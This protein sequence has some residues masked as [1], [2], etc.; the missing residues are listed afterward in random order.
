MPTL[1]LIGYRGTGK[2]TVARQLAL[3]LEWDW[4]DADVEIE[5]A[6]GKSIAAIFA[7]DG[8]PAFRELESRV[9]AGLLGRERT[10]VAAGGGAVLRPENRAAIQSAGVVVWLQAQPATLWQRLQGDAT[11]A[12]RR[13]DL[14]RHGGLAEIEALLAERTPWYAA[15]ATLA[16]DTEGKSPAQIADEILRRLDS[17]FQAGPA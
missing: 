6:A 14:T 1:V 9:L 5:L 4:V 8:E 15:C 11:T 3:R 12:A 7:D 10:I 17:G 13:P 16:I 2:S